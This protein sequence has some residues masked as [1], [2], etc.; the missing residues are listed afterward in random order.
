MFSFFLSNAFKKVGSVFVVL[1]V[2]VYVIHYINNI[3]EENYKLH[4][5]IKQMEAI[6]N[7]CQ[8][9]KRIYELYCTTKQEIEATGV[10]DV[11][12]KDKNNSDSVIFDFN[13]L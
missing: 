2:V 5:K 12:V 10:D 11:K 7:Q 9:E 6:F 13:R 4:T 3:K 8:D 1:L